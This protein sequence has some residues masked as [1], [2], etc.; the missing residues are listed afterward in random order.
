MRAQNET[1]LTDNAWV[2]RIGQLRQ[3][4][5]DQYDTS[6][7]TTPRE[8]VDWLIESADE[9]F[10]SA[11]ERILLRHAEDMRREWDEMHTEQ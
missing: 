10:D 9:E 5:S 1:G 11:D 6:Q 3:M 2:Q 7:N 4:V 8:F